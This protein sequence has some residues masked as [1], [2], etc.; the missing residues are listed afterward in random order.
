MQITRADCLS[1][2][3]SFFLYFFLSFFLSFSTCRIYYFRSD[4]R[5]RYIMDDGLVHHPLSFPFHQEDGERGQT[6]D[7]SER[8]QKEEKDDKFRA[9]D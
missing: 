4:K 6:T 8:N 5:E 9:E 1:F 7:I 2:F 3:L